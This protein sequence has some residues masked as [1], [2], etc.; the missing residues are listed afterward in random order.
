MS[1]DQQNEDGWQ[2]ALKMTG[3]V[4]IFLGFGAVAAEALW[5]VDFGKADHYGL[6]QWV[7]LVVGGAGVA[8]LV[9]AAIRRRVR[10]RVHA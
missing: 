3:A 10:S 4:L 1:T 2:S 5:D 6:P 8:F 7:D 9:G